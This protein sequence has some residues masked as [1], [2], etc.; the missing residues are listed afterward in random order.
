M[1]KSLDPYGDY[2]K[3]FAVDKDGNEAK[4]KNPNIEYG[5]RFTRQEVLDRLKATIKAGRPIIGTGCASGLIGRAEEVGGSDMIIA[6]HT[7]RARA[8]GM[9]SSPPG[10]NPNTETLD[11]AAE[12]LRTIEATPVICGCDT[13][14]LSWKLEDFLDE[15]VKVG[16]S[17]IIIFPTLSLRSPYDSIGGIIAEQYTGNGL[18]R[19]IKAV[20]LAHERDLFV[21]TYI[22][23]EEAARAY[24]K[25]GIDAVCVHCG[26]TIGG[27]REYA[28]NHE[29]ALKRL[30]EVWP[31]GH[32]GHTVDTVE[33]VCKYV[34]IVLDW[35][36]EE[37]PNVIPMAHGGILAVPNPLVQYLYDKTDAVG[38]LGASSFER[39]PVEKGVADQVIAFKK[40]TLPDKKRENF[41]G[42]TFL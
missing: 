22:V 15:V 36:K 32:Q 9:T 2:A 20:K 10:K 33:G 14:D 12:I 17:G 13:T 3:Y 11:L 21:M 37:N 41:S 1:S 39:I 19:E 4:V 40:Q 35:V 8:R 6:Y 42:W 27:I 30:R 38:F 34:Q 5:R 23:F 16:A 7:D 26:G 31:R 28:P 29:I 25:A 24:A 18:S